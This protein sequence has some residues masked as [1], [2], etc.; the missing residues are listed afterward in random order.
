MEVS[1]EH[2]CEI[3]FG[4][5]RAAQDLVQHQPRYARLAWSRAPSRDEGTGHTRFSRPAVPDALHPG[6]GQRGC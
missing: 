1:N 3:S 5:E 6:G 4:R 2:N